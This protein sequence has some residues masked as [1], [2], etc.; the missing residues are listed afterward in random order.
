MGWMASLSVELFLKPFP[1]FIY[2]FFSVVILKV[3][4][5]DVF[6]NCQPHT[7]TKGTI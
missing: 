5:A 1:L 3:Y 2:L 4:H 6:A 7:M